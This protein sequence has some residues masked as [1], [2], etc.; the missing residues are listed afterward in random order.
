MVTVAGM[1]DPV[2]N[3]GVDDVGKVRDIV[4][5]ICKRGRGTAMVIV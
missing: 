5:R 4:W 2:E 1:R 3:K